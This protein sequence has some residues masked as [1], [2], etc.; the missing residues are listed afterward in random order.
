MNHVAGIIRPLLAL[1]LAMPAGSALAA[2][3]A[4]G[5][6]QT[7]AIDAVGGEVRCWGRG[8][9]GELGEGHLNLLAHRA[10]PGEVAT[11]V[12]LHSIASGGRHSCGLSA[13]GGVY[14]WGYNASGQLGD[15]TTLYRDVPTAVSGL[16][17]NVTALAL[18][19]AHTCALLAGGSVKCWGESDDGR[20]GTGDTSDQTQPR[21]VLQLSGASEIGA[22]NAHTCART[23]SGMRCWGDN[24]YGQVG[25][26]TWTTRTIPVTT[27]IAMSVAS[28]AVGGYHTCA[29]SAAGAVQCWGRNYDGQLGDGT[30][31][32]RNLPVNADGLSGGVT[33]LSA[34]G[35]HTCALAAGATLKCWGANSNGQ[36]GDGTTDRRERPTAVVDA[37]VPVTELSLGEVHTCVRGGANTF[38][39]WGDANYGKL[40]RFTPSNVSYSNRPAAV[41]GLESPIVALSTFEQTTCAVTDTGG[42]RCWGDNYYGQLGNGVEFSGGSMIDF[43]GPSRVVSLHADVR[44]IAAGRYHA[45]AAKTDGSVWCW[46]RNNY[47]QLADGTTINR[48]TPVQVAGIDDAVALVA[49]ESFTCVLS[50]GGGV[51]CWGRNNVGQIGD[52]S[53][54][55]RGQPVDVVGLGAGVIALTAGEEHVCALMDEDH[56]S[57][58][59]CWGEGGNGRLGDGTTTDRYLPTP[60]D[61]AGTAYLAVSAGYFH[62]CGITAA[63]RA[64]C[65][66]Y[67]GS[68][69]IGD[70]TTSQRTSPTGVDGLA[71]GVTLLSTGDR[72]TCALHDGQPKCW[73]SNG[74]Y[75]LGDGSTTSRNLPTPVANLGGSIAMLE[76][77][78]ASSCAR[79]SDGRTRCWGYNGDGRLGNGA[80]N[81]YQMFPIDVSQWSYS[82]VIFA[83]GFE[84]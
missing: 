79:M 43:S 84:F 48:T 14:C 26:G 45:C 63:G 51:R 29:R 19:D 37:P 28:I 31:S 62:T 71:S 55:D 78:D 77:G 49:G 2:T 80:T 33:R 53:L 64:K 7:C 36:V 5:G 83:D 41:T 56:G 74:Y 32:N 22:G 67:N 52:G 54:E 27:Q 20:L 34:G 73:G 46:G 17:G 69:Q 15:G 82:D 40:G 44:D 8:D 39:C 25:D 72:H 57:T 47:F 66:G 61:D 70:G 76:L 24:S 38:H 23:G 81:S 60:I 18:G 12:A 68:G 58:V 13:A 1:A 21:D 11:S 30:T 59:Q 16:S 4:A 65:W 75:Q 9:A 10:A 42:A 3:L 6:S 35:Y 50:A